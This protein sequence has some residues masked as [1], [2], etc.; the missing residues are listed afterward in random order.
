MSESADLPFPFVDPG[1]LVDGKLSL[2]LL[3]N[4]T[5]RFATDVIP[6]VAAKYLPSGHLLYFHAGTHRVI[7]FDPV[8]QRVI[9]DSVK[10]LPD[11]RPMNPNSKIFVGVGHGFINAAEG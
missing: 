8:A 2:T 4:Y 11:A 1:P 9:G 5:H 3:R 10:V 6:G 7:G